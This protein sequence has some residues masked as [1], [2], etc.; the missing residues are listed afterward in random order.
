MKTKYLFQKNRRISALTLL[1]YPV[2]IYIS[3]TG[4]LLKKY[5]FNITGLASLF[6]LM[7]ALFPCH[8][9]A[10]TLPLISG[11]DKRLT[12]IP[13]SINTKY[14][15]N[16]TTVNIL[17]KG[18]FPDY[19]TNTLDNPPRV[20]VDIHSA[21]RSFQSMT[22]PV[23]C[24][25]LKSIRVGYHSNKIR[26]VLDIKGTR[27][28]AFSTASANN[29]LT[30]FFK[31][32]AAMKNHGGNTKGSRPKT[33]LPETDQENLSGKREQPGV[34]QK[35]PAQIAANYSKKSIQTQR[36]LI[37]KAKILHQ[38]KSNKEALS[39]LENLARKY[40]GSPEETG[41]K[42]EISMILYDMNNFR[43]S[44]KI[45]NE[46]KKSDPQNIYKF[47]EISL[48]TGY[49][50]F[51]LGDNVRSRENLL[52]FYNTCPDK[53][54][55]HLILT[56][57]GDT[58]RNQDLKKDAMIFYHLVIERYPDSEGSIISQLRLAE[59]Q[60]E[61]ETI[62]YDKI[63]GKEIGSPEKIY[64]EIIKNPSV[65]NANSPLTQFAM[66]KLGI[67][68]QEEKKYDKSLKTLK[69]LLAKRPQPSLRKECKHALLKTMTA[70]FN[71]M[72]KGGEY[73]SVVNIY[74]RDKEL[75]LMLNSP[76]LLI[77]LARAYLNLNLKDTATAIF[78]KADS[79]LLD[80][81]KS[82]DLL[83]FLSQ[84]LYKNGEFKT[85][86]AKLDFLINKYP[87]GKYAHSACQ[88]KGK[89]LFKQKK[90]PQAVKM[91]SSALR[92]NLKRCEKAEILID[93]AKALMA[94]NLNDNAIIAT[95][96]ADS[97]KGDCHVRY[98]H[99]YKDIGDVYLNLGY[100]KEALSVF[101][102]ALD[103]EKNAE[104]RILFKLKAA[105]CYR[106]L[107]KKEDSLALYDQI[108]G[109]NVPFWSNL[110]KERIDEIKFS[111]EIFDN[112]TGETKAE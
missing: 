1:H 93:K 68:Y 46:L 88:L 26:M 85:A 107:N 57:I 5:L 64:Q 28:P 92:F 47:P 14:D 11:P 9:N 42:K 43:K 82:P 52:K 67:L 3:T 112:V 54:I 12:G 84:D 36:I 74:Q 103:I 104:N 63:I 29:R 19:M 106:L 30:L 39:I 48:Y 75:F 22:I 34:S 105:Q 79:L 18:K 78:K 95:K 7:T 20:I 44:L 90:F 80:K 91:F 99:I 66:L 89:I 56:K 50:Y 4:I 24:P 41:V 58:Y 101:N 25:N 59:F 23:N 83:F 86:L 35:K 109:L 62:S 60:K 96:K 32:G 37:K 2:V 76:E 77:I 17:W 73:T 21:A 8:L 111:G 16:G 72:M 108:A 53:G 45:L 65:K 61:G 40:P 69:D 110:A 55:N 10:T 33:N 87:S 102:Q 81:E 6:I 27:K 51:Q 38:K 15:K 97:L 31:S 100:T 13:V 49:N 70:K 71:K 98:Q 94:Q